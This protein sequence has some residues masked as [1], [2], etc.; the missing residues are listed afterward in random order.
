MTWVSR[1]VAH[2]HVIDG[3]AVVVALKAEAGGAVGLRIAI[4]QEDFEAFQSEA[5]GE[6]DGC[7]GLAN[8]ALLVDNTENL[9]HGY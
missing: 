2:Q 7:C 6:V 8:S 4:D 5:G 1:S 9:S 3:M